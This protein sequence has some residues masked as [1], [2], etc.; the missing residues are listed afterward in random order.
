VDDVAVSKH[1]AI[2]RKDETGSAA[3]PFARFAVAGSSSLRDFDLRDRRA[4]FFGGSD[5]GMGVSVEQFGI[6]QSSC[7]MKCGPVEFRARNRLFKH[8]R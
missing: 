4:D 5:N 3:L 1:Q 7:R 8:D 6:M 2:G